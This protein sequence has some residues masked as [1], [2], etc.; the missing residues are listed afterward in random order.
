M[1]ECGYKLRLDPWATEYEGAVQ[2]LEQEEL[3]AEVDTTV[4]GRAW[5]AIRPEP[6]SSPRRILFVD[7]VRR[8]DYRILVEQGD[9]ILYGL[10][11]ACGVGT[12]E[13][14]E[15]ASV[16]TQQAIARVVCV[17]GG[18]ELPRLVVPVRNGRLALE[19]LPLPVAENTPAAP[20]LGLQSLMRQHEAELAH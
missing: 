3:E 14:A 19:F 20:L 8:I 1:S 12:T 18:L 9:R 11:G 15:A 16:M 4:E 6:E 13:V 10:L 7:G 17:G 5:A 2:L